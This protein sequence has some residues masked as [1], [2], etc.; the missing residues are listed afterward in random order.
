MRA[1]ASGQ[2]LRIMVLGGVDTGKSTFCRAALAAMTNDGHR[3]ALIDADVGQKIVGPPAAVTVA[4]GAAPEVLAGL[5]FVG[6]TNPL[7][8]FSRLIEGVRDLRL[9]FEDC[10]LVTNTSGLVSAGG[11]ALKRAKIGTFQPD[12]LVAI[13]N[14]QKLDRIL[15]GYSGRCVRLARSPLAQRKSR[16][17][18]RLA[19]QEAFRR[20]FE[21]A[22]VQRISSEGL[23]ALAHEGRPPPQRLLVGLVD[24]RDRDLALGLLLRVEGRS[25]SVLAPA[26]PQA[27]QLT[28]GQ[29]VLDGDFRDAGQVG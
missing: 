3:A 13:G 8:G 2:F 29:L 7:Q 16:G 22:V 27:T 12:L 6:T 10:I 26:A 20:Y 23:E 1:A 25:A 14:D 19:R 21:G 28:P 24:D 4:D 11:K 15:A 18:R 9:S 5:A 17:D